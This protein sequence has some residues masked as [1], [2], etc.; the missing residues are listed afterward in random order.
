M[1]DIPELL[2]KR[3][4]VTLIVGKPRCRHDDDDSDERYEDLVY[5]LHFS[6]VCVE[7][8]R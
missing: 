4:H 2:N 8:R 3:V 6:M 7:S 5:V 1:K